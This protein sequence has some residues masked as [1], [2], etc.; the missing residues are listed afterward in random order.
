[1]FHLTLPF[2][3][4]NLLSSNL[5]FCQRRHFVFVFSTLLRF[6]S[7][8]EKNNIFK[9]VRDVSTFKESAWPFKKFA[10]IHI[11]L[12]IFHLYFKHY[13]YELLTLFIIIIF[14]ISDNGIV[15][16]QIAKWQEKI[17]VKIYYGKKSVNFAI[18][19]T[20]MFL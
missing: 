1:M 13:H 16:F 12:W 7:V 9:N 8:S 18:E 5:I 10:R 14:F 20:E 17:I 3:Y 4:Q 6:N 2:L 11:L 15:Q 19:S